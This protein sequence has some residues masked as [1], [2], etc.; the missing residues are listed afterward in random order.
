MQSVN[1][2]L[3]SLSPDIGEAIIQA[4]EEVIDGKWDDQFLVDVYQAG[5]GTSQKYECKRSH[6]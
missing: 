2:E 3:G 4:S 6:C 1:V 5:A